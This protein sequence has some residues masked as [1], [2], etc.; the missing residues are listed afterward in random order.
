M[1]QEKPIEHRFELS[2]MIKKFREIDEDATSDTIILKE[3]QDS[4][5]KTP[6]V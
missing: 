4:L 6:Q 3:F 5:K 1:K 2:R